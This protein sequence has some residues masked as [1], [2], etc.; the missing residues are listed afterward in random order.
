MNTNPEPSLQSVLPAATRDVIAKSMSEDFRSNLKLPR[1]MDRH[2][3]ARAIDYVLL[4]KLTIEETQRKMGLLR[5]EVAY[6]TAVIDEFRQW[7]AANKT[8]TPAVEE[9]KS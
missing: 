4:G 5:S 6:I 2:L 7:E 8:E 9:A 3:V 1:R